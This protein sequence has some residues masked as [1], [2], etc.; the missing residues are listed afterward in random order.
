MGGDD[1]VLGDEERQALAA[2]RPEYD[3][4][5]GVEPG[6]NQILLCRLVMAGPPTARALRRPVEDVAVF[7]D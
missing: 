7:E 2:L 3:A 5:F 6:M 4:L 1:E